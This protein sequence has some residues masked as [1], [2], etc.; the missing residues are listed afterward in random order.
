MISAHWTYG[1]VRRV[2]Q[3]RLAH[4]AQ[5]GAT[6]SWSHA[7]YNGTVPDGGSVMFGFNGSWSGGNP[8]LTVTLG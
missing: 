4:R 3:D 7:S 8:L 1:A 6:V 2:T 5:T